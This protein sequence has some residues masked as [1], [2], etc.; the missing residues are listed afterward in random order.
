MLRILIVGAGLFIAAPASAQSVTSW[1]ATSGIEQF[2]LTDIVR[3]KPPVDASPVAWQGSGPMFSIARTRR[4]GPRL[5]RLEFVL[6][7]TNDFSYRSQQ[8]EF[9]ADPEDS[10][11][12]L[13]GRYE[14]HRDVLTRHVP[15][16]LRTSIG[17]RG[18]GTWLSMTQHV[19]PT[20]DISKSSTDACGAFVV[21]ATLAP[22][23]RLSL[24]VN[25]A[26]GLRIGRVSPHGSGVDETHAVGG[27]WTTDLALT[28]RVRLTPRYAI[29]VRF[30]DRGD[31]IESSHRSFTTS[32]RQLSVG[33]IYA[34]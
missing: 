25:Y 18:S 21:A 27:G 26:N 20:N 13:E 8:R 19:P 5:H 1:T 24:D 34:K 12:H 9:A 11:L 29:A 31:G 33:V 7:D 6:A 28:G 16:W 17:V 4:S 22:Q 30:F 15:A 32:Q 3:G 23:K 10:A 14:Y 2:A